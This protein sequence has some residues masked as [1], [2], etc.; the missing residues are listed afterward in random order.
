MGDVSQVRLTILGGGGF[1][2]PLVYQA[3]L[4]D[5]AER[6]VAAISQVTLYDPDPQRVAVIAEILRQQ[7]ARQPHPPTVRISTDLAHAVRGA[8]FVFS[9]VRVG[10]L[11]GRIQDEQVAREYGLLGQETVGAGGIAYG[12]RTVPVARQIARTVADHAPEAWLINFTNPAGLVTE[13]MRPLLGDRAIGICDSPA[14]LVRGALAAVGAQPAS[15]VELD[16]V[17]LNHLGW[18]REISID[19]VPRLAGLL[20]DDAALASFEEGRLFGGEWLRALGCLPNEYLHYFYLAR[21]SRDAGQQDGAAGA[22]VASG[23]G[24][25]RASR[26]E[27]LAAQQ[28]AFYRQARSLIWADQAADA[29]ESR[30]ALRLWQRVKAERDATYFAAERA[31]SGAGERAERDVELGGYEQIALELMRALSNTAAPD[32]AHPADLIVNVANRGLLPQFDADAVI[33][34]GCR[35]GRDG[36]Q[37]HSVAPLTE[38][39]AG[40]MCSVKAV[41]RAVIEAATTGS[42]DAALR[43]F[44]MHPLVDSVSIAAGLLDAY[45]ERHPELNYLSRKR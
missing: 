5:A 21:E 23:A 15:N 41:E 20:A 18:L 33:E 9:A 4:A 17:G 30:S 34:V 10:G 1:R 43:A 22:S 31:V 39:Q 35:V 2:V 16:Y 25:S 3:L 32:P 14:S 36:P 38:H 44:A 19:G 37:P 7:A 42:R 12:L 11:A 40:L 26:G 27:F 8:D 13:A 45:A 6:G 29:H 24:A 28:E